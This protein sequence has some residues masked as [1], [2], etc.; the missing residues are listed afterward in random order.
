MATVLP[1]RPATRSTAR[2]TFF[3]ASAFVRTAGRSSRSA[4]AASTVPAQ[5]RK[6][7]AVKACPV[8]SRR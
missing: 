2:R 3:F 6:S 5:V 8:T 4:Q 7:F 1:R